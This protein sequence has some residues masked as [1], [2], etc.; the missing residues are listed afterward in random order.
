MRLFYTLFF[1]PTI[2][3]AIENNNKYTTISV[4]TVPN[5]GENKRTLLKG[6]ITSSEDS[7]PV[8]Y[9]MIH[10]DGTT[11]GTLTDDKG[12]YQLPLI[13]GNYKVKVTHLSFAEYSFDVNNTTHPRK[14]DIITDISLTPMAISAESVIVTSQSKSQ[15]LKEQGFA[16]TSIGTQKALFSTITT[17]ELVNNTPGV[18]IRQSGGLGSDMNYSINGLSDNSVRVYI[19]GVSIRNYGSNFTVSSIP[20]SLIERIDVFKGV[21][22]AYLADDALG[23]AINIILKQN[24]INMLNTSYSYGSHNTHRADI[25]GQFRTKKS[26]ITAGAS[27]YYN[28][29]DNDYEVWGDNVIYVTDMTTF[30]NENVRARRFHDNYESYGMAGNIGLSHVNWADKLRAEIRYSEINKDIQHGASMEVVYGQRRTEQNSIVANLTYEKRNILPRL[31]VKVLASYSHSNRLLIDTCTYIYGWHGDIYTSNDGTPLEWTKGGGEGGAAS[32]ENNME[33]TIVG[34]INLDYALDKNR[35]HKISFNTMYSNFSRDV[36]DP[37]LSVLEQ[38]LTETRI[39][40]KLTSSIS[41][42][43][44]LINDKLKSSIFYKLFK[45]SATLVDPIVEDG[46]TI[47]Q[48]YSNNSLNGGYGAALSYAVL[49]KVLITISGEKAVRLPSFTELLGDVSNNIEATIDLKP[50][51][52]TN[53]NI[54]TLISDISLGLSSRNKIN[55]NANVFYRDV[56]NLIEKSVVNQNDDLYGYENIGKMLSKGVDAEIN[57]TRRCVKNELF[58]SA[59]AGYADARFNLKYNEFGVAYDQYNNRMRNQPYLTA[60]GE[61]SFRIYNVFNT[62]GSLALNYNTNYTHEFYVNWE[63]YGSNNKAIVPTQFTHDIGAVYTFPKN[64]YSLSFDA[65]NIFDEQVFDN[66]ALQKPGRWLSV[67]FNCRIF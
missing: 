38:M 3:F 40:N 31:D 17:D 42:D 64:N 26:G 9:A 11:I 22:P 16:L 55:I 10:I 48:E 62:K 61:V 29:S 28:Y 18:K 45:Q 4:E 41:Y 27:A 49:P 30:R 19:D 14:D 25:N 43:I 2:I 57:Y 60:G 13:H 23:G 54:G 20:P 24:S 58:I 39:I 63:C 37:Y 7:S 44:N 59:N 1:L 21:V 35:K 33:N 50:E 12:Y 67:K 6:L 52:S 36:E 56:S 8:A 5:E 53:L 34:R 32:M 47:G 65:K 66:Y 15:Q 51:Q 46:V